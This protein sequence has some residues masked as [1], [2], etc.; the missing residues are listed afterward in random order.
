MLTGM[1]YYLGV[2]SIPD[3]ADAIDELSFVNVLNRSTMQIFTKNHERITVTIGPASSDDDFSKGL[4]ILIGGSFTSD[5]MTEIENLSRLA[6]KP[7]TKLVAEYVAR[8]AVA[9]QSQSTSVTHRIL[10]GE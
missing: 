3:A 1:L 10:G 6:D 8:Q 4:M 9:M 7:V 5:E 2:K